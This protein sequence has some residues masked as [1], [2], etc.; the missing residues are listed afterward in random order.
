[1]PEICRSLGIII[2]MYF[3]DHSPPHFHVEYG[4]YPAIIEIL[5]L[6]LFG[7]SLPPRVLGLVT[8]WASQHQAELLAL[9]ERARNGQPLYKLPPLT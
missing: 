8:E 2:K 6:V 4:E 3:G 9:W 7:G 1:M 5:T